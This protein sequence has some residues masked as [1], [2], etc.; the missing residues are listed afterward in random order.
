MG[1]A[2]GVATLDTGGKV[3]VAQLPDY[4]LGQLLWG[5]SFN[6]TSAVATLSTNAKSKL[7]VTTDTI[8]LTNDNTAI[9]GYVANE[10]IYYVTQTAG[11]FA[12]IT[13]SVG[14]WLLSNGTE[15]GK[16]DNTDAVTSVNGQIGT[17]TI[18]TPGTL[19]TTS[20]TALTTSDSESLSG[21]I[22]LHKIAKTGTNTD[23]IDYVGRRTGSDHGEVFNDYADS[24]NIASGKWSHAE[25][26]F[27]TAGG[28][29]S[30]GEG[31]NTTANGNS[32][33]AEGSNTVASGN[34]SHAQNLGTIANGAYQTA[35]GKF[36][37]AD[38]TSALIIGGGAN[39]S[40]RWNA[41]TVDWNGVVRLHNSGGI[42][43]IGNPY[44]LEIPTLTSNATIA[45]TDD[46]AAKATK[47]TITLTGNAVVTSFLITH[48]LNTLNVMV[49]V[50]D[51]TTGEDVMLDIARKS[52]NEI[53]VTFASAPLATES[54]KVVVIG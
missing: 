13:F 1:V 17:V 6:A 50:Y 48:N 34:S 20:T 51:I 44:K 32:S 3:A 45:T 21:A 47:Y 22:S 36:N 19:N 15:W 53:T 42:G 35:I 8:T 23:L 52:V 16:I 27:V 18:P 2:S 12:G 33:H 26:Y 24:A 29:K 49:S 7:N 41:L 37:A 11:T 14:D 40:E 25:G 43:D 5:G 10:G 28:T 9:T 30:H 46:V 39:V 38:T 31:D 54:Y 4:I